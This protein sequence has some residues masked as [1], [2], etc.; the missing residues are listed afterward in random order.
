MT[1]KEDSP[2]LMMEP[3]ITRGSL[4]LHLLEKRAL[5]NG[6]D[7]R[8]TQK[9]FDVLRVLVQNEERDVSCEMLC[10][11]VWRIPMKGNSH[12]IRLCVCRLKKDRKSVV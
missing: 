3:V 9:E 6:E 5:I 7:V 10:E 4:T 1:L 8:L 2:V 12:F 11:T